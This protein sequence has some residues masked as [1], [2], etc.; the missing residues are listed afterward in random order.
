MNRPLQLP[1]SQRQNCYA[2]WLKGKES[3]ESH[4]HM[5]PSIIRSIQLRVKMARD[6]L[7]KANGARSE[8]FM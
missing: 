5:P 3:P 8:I 7:T 4:M 2:I 1:A 6:Q